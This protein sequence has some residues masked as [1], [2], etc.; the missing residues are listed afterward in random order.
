MSGVSISEWQ[1][2]KEQGHA[3]GLVACQT[4]INLFNEFG[5]QSMIQPTIDWLNS[6]AKNTPTGS[7][8]W[9]GFL[10]YADSL[11]V[12][13]PTLAMLGK[14]TGDKKYYD[15]LEAFFWD[16]HSEIYDTESGLFYRDIRFMQKEDKENF[17]MKQAQAI[18]RRKKGQLRYQ[19]STNGRK[20]FW[21]RG[22][23]WSAL[24]NGIGEDGRVL[25]GQKVGGGPYTIEKESTHEYVTGAFLL[26]DSEMLKLIKTPGE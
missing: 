24:Y 7:E 9:Y 19:I 25:W 17:T 18:P 14:T 16:V 13:C 23:G 10:R 15:Y 20:V 1:P 3:N 21:A 22:N 6:G 26:A 4:Y 11:F 8:L 5:D 12:G 2:E